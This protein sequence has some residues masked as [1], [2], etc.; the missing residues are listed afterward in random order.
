MTFDPVDHLPSV[1]AHRKALTELGELSREGIERMIE[2]AKEAAEKD[3]PLEHG[4]VAKIEKENLYRLRQG[5]YRALIDYKLGQVRI[6]LVA[7]RKDVYD[8]N[9]LTKASHRAKED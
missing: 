9:K 2:S 4:K 5:S 8:T 7:H 3:H 1:L 6:L